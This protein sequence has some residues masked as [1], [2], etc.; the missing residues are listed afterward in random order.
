MA[1]DNDPVGRGDSVNETESLRFFGEVRAPRE[2]RL[3]SFGPLRAYLEGCDLR[4]ICVGETELIRRIYVAVRDRNWQTIENEVEELAIDESEGGFEARVVVRNRSEEIDFRWEA[5][6]SGDAEGH[7]VYHFTG[8]ALKDF[9]KN[10]IGLCILQPSSAAGRPCRY[11]ETEARDSW[12]EGRLPEVIS[13]HQPFKRLARFAHEAAGGLWASLEF[14]G[15]IFEMEDQRNWTDA[16][17]K[18]YSTPLELP[19]P[20]RVHEGEAI[21]QEVTLV[22]EGARSLPHPGSEA[23]NVRLGPVSGATLVPIGF[24]LNEPVRGRPASGGKEALDRFEVEAIRRLSPHHLRIDLFPGLEAW[25]EVLEAALRW[26][27]RLERPLWVAVNAPDGGAP[28]GLAEVVVRNAPHVARLLLG[29]ST[30]PWVGDVEALGRLQRVLDEAAPEVRVGIGTSGWFTELNR[31]PPSSGRPD[32]VFWSITP[33]VHAFDD[34]SLIETLS[35][36]ATTVESARRLFPGVP[37]VVGPVTLRMRFNPNATTS[38]NPLQA[39]T[40][41]ETADPRQRG[42]FAAAFSLLSA[43]YVSEGGAASLTFGELVGPRGVIHRFSGIAQPPF[44]GHPEAR[45]FPIYPLL[46]ELSALAGWRLLLF[47]SERILDVDGLA[48]EHRGEVRLYVANTSGVEQNV[49]FE[50]ADLAVRGAVLLDLEAW[51][52]ATTDT[53]GTLG[54]PIDAPD[55]H[56]GLELSLPPWSIA[57]VIARGS[58]P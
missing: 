37:C 45:V 25:D 56:S 7:L 32:F 14:S 23:V 40:A 4:Y 27:R 36:Q 17:F 44:G 52:G 9:E 29:S 48:V 50:G 19:F 47:E 30:P 10:R 54:R 43:R 22:A 33:Q 21:E 35:C 41:G 55:G 20:V 26:A 11:A 57:R 51:E 12:K 28:E 15:D 34:R 16:S 5:N 53:N 58:V 49:R 24:T 46:R 8:R 13:P 1:Q 38:E 6:I 3:V 2:R 42:L 18:I 31:T 39:M